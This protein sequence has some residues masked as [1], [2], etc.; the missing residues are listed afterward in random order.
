M[1]VDTAG[2]TVV[3][4][5]SKMQA[6]TIPR[7]LG[8]RF[9]ARGGWGAVALVAVPLV[10]GC[11]R[12]ARDDRI[13]E[14]QPER[15]AGPEGGAEL[16]H[17]P[18]AEQGTGEGQP[19]TAGGGHAAA[20][21]E[22]EASGADR[23]DGAQVSADG[24]VNPCS[25]DGW[26]R[27]ETGLRD[28]RLLAID[29]TR[30]D[31]VVVVG[32]GSTVLHWRGDEWK[33]RAIEDDV[34]FTNVHIVAEDE[35]Y[36]GGTKEP[37]PPPGYIF[38][39]D[40]SEWSLDE[41]DPSIAFPGDIAEDP[42]GDLFL[43]T[44]H[45][46][47]RRDDEGWRAFEVE[48]REVLT[49]LWILDDDAV[50]AFGTEMA[51]SV[52]RY[53]GDAWEEEEISAGRPVRG[54]WGDDDSAFAVGSEGRI[55]EWQDETWQPYDEEELRE[56]DLPPDTHLNDVWGAGPDQVFVVGEVRRERSTVAGVTLHYDG[57]RWTRADSGTERSLYSVWGRSHDDVYAA[58]QDGAL[59]HWDGARW[60]M[61][62]TPTEASL[63]EVWGVGP[64]TLFAIGAEGT[65]LRRHSDP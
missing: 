53:D 28:E 5:M 16:D 11:P 22:G 50:F 14:A 40:G 17:A 51:G 61:K 23:R 55:L 57:E 42:G 41:R 46:I 6:R 7:K 27:M 45:D 37:G 65:I 49:R 39:Y 21:A 12:S 63:V 38:R 19:R 59:I 3:A 30:P 18:E 32:S 62:E 48:P 8:R 54:V 10:L 15:A 1:L 13:D 24:A 26:C 44:G 29:G 52:Y 4:L 47:W 31:N 20:E 58:G 34:R 9:R 36:A 60:S 56:L 43:A 2:P 64:D 25:E 33:R 35:M